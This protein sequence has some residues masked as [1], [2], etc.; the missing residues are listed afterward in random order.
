MLLKLNNSLLNKQENPFYI[1]DKNKLLEK[2]NIFKNNFNGK[3]LYA[4]K[5]NP[6]KLIIK[7]LA[8]Q[9]SDILLQLQLSLSLKNFG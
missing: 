2:I 7:L 3:I 4:I 6:Y 8:E 9:L 1:F 5:A